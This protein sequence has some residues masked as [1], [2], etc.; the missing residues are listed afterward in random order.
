M[1][2]AAQ[3]TPF[4][5]RHD[6]AVD[7]WLGAQ[8]ERFLHLV[9]RGRDAIALHAVADEKKELV[10]LFGEHEGLSRHKSENKS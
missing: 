5:E 7:A 2:K 3:E 4:L 10:L 6:E 8:L 1:G 9:E